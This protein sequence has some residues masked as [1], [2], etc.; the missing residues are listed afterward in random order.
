MKQIVKNFNNLIK[1]T[2][3]KVQNKTNTKFQIST[4]N[5]YFISLIGLLFLYLFYLLIPVLYDKDWLQNS[6]EG[7]I[8]NEFK[9]NVSSSSDISYRILPAPHFLIKNSKILLNIDKN[10]KTIADVKNLRIFLSQKN[11]FN[12]E[13]IVLKKLIIANANFTLLRKEFKI[14]NDASNNRLSK[15]KIQIYNSKIFFKD[16]LQE[17]VTIIKVHKATLFF[18]DENKS[19]IFNLKGNLFGIPFT[20]AL[21]GKTDSVINKRVS[22]N[23]KSLKLNIINEFSVEDDNSNK[24]KNIISF[25]NSKIKTN[26]SM[27]EKLLTFAS[28]NSRLAGSR[29][30]Y[31]GDLSI[32]PFDLNLNIDLGDYKISKLFNLNSILKEFIKSELLFNDNLSLDIAILAKTNALGEIFDTAEINFSILNGKI[33]FNNTKFINNNIG[34][35]KLSN[36]NLF[37]E[38]DKLIFNADLIFEINNSDRLYS[39]LNTAKRSRKEIRNILINLDYDFLSN[40]IRFNNVRIDNNKVSD[41]FLNVIEGFNNNNFNNSIKSRRLLNELFNIYDG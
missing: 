6:I 14:L 20:F 37:L 27:K 1:K 40:E 39:L 35:L 34:L 22:F 26:Y 8:F 18:N 4:F 36:S 41:K 21:Q 7:K 2:L 29:I 33:N 11:F 24:G 25:L 16:N 31:N 38:N 30:N 15:K 28:D 3:L 19:N 17:I 5:K 9:I 32:N 23:A 13:K 10:Q 12:K